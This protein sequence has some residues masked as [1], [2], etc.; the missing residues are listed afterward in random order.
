MG[1][2]PGLKLRGQLATLLGEA[3]RV[4][5]KWGDDE[6]VPSALQAR[7]PRLSALGPIT[8]ASDNSHT[9]QGF[10]GDSG[11]KESA[12]NA[13]DPG[14]ISASGR[15][16]GEGN[17]YPLQYSH[18]GNSMDREARWTTIHGVA[19]SRAGLSDSHIHTLMES[20]STLCLLNDYMNGISVSFFIYFTES[21]AQST[22]LKYTI[23]FEEIKY[24]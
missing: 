11:S 23:Q 19:K 9:E 6:P 5:G 1:K 7:A 12:S 4:W 17:G 14:S 22:L 13:G 21:K 20:R 2:G 8:P 3:P 18:L 16:P 10:P 15:S 24:T